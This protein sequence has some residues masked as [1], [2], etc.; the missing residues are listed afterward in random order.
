MCTFAHMQT[1][2]ISCVTQAA[3]QRSQ[4]LAI[5]RHAYICFDPQGLPAA[6]PEPIKP[7]LAYNYLGA[8]SSHPLLDTEHMII[9]YVSQFLPPINPAFCCTTFGP[10]GQKARPCCHSS[11]CVKQ[12]PLA[13]GVRLYTVHM[14]INDALPL[15][16]CLLSTQPPPA[17]QSSQHLVFVPNRP[18]L[19]SNCCRLSCCMKQPPVA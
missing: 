16:G 17:A 11:C 9:R 14:Y 10:Q 7:G 19:A 6:L 4:P 3:L 13:W 2:R 15:R 1:R 18:G 12:P 5:G 8:W